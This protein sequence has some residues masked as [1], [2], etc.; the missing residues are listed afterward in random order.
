[1]APGAVSVLESRLNKLA[2][3]KASSPRAL[4]EVLKF[5]QT[6]K[7]DKTEVRKE[8]VLVIIGRLYDTYIAP[9]D[10][11]MVPDLIEGKIDSMIKS[12][13]M[14]VVDNFLDSFDQVQ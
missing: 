14:S 3:E 7:G 6:I 5:L 13:F 12:Y 10:I 8:D 11:P 4:A 9:L 1:M 2:T